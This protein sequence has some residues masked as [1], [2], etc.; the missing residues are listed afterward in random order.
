VNV[1]LDLFTHL[2]KPL[3][4]LNNVFYKI[5]KHGKLC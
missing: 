1:V 3:H 5:K 2:N 4:L